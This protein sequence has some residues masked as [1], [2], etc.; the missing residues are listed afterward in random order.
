MGGHRLLVTTR[1][2]TGQRCGRA[3]ATDVVE[4]AGS[5][6]QVGVQWH[7]HHIGKSGHLAHERHQVVGG[8]H[9]GGVVGGPV[10][11]SHRK[12]TSTQVVHQP[13]HEAH[14][15]RLGGHREPGAHQALRPDLGVRQR[16]Q[17]VQRR[18]QDVGVQDPEAGGPGEVRHHGGGD[19]THPGRHLAYGRIGGGQHEQVDATGRR[20]GVVLPAQ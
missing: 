9:R 8:H 6:V 16:H 19:R 17:R 2:R 20:C 7:A 12:R 15:G 1:H 18:T 14:G 5:Q 3:D 10:A 11:I 4:R 13:L